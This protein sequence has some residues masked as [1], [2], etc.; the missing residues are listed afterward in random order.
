MDLATIIQQPY[1]SK[2][3]VN[4][5][6]ATDEKNILA[7][8]DQ[9]LSTIILLDYKQILVLSNDQNNLANFKIA[10]LKTNPSVKDFVYEIIYSP[11][12]DKILIICE[13]SIYLTHLPFIEDNFVEKT[14]QIKKVYSHKSLK[15]GK[16]IWLS[17]NRFAFQTSNC[18]KIYEFDNQIQN[19]Q[20]THKYSTQ[21]KLN[22]SYSEEFNGF[23]FIDQDDK[24]ILYRLASFNN[25]HEIFNVV[26][27][28]KS[29]SPN[30][31]QNFKILTLSWFNQ[32]IYSI[33]I[34]NIITH[35][36]LVNDE[37][38]GKSQVESTISGDSENLVIWCFESL[39]LEQDILE[40]YNDNLVPNRYYVK[41][42]KDVYSITLPLNTDNDENDLP[43][44]EVYHIFHDATSTKSK[45]SNI[46]GFTTTSSSIFSI[47]NNKL[48]NL[49]KIGWNK[50]AEIQTDNVT[51]DKTKNIDE[52]NVLTLEIA[53]ML[54]KEVLQ[55][56]IIRSKEDRP[57]AIEMAKTLKNA[58]SIINCEYIEKH[59]NVKTVLNNKKSALIKKIDLL[60]KT[61]SQ[62]QSVNQT[63]KSTNQ[64]LINKLAT[65]LENQEI[66]EKKL[67]KVRKFNTSGE[68]LSKQEQEWMQ[69]AKV[70]EENLTNYKQNIYELK[71]EL[72]NE[73][74]NSSSSAAFGIK[75]RSTFDS[76][77]QYHDIESNLVK[78]TN[79]LENLV[80][81]LKN[82]SIK[83]G[84]F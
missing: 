66:L 45:H 9:N 49:P 44:A 34:G 4:I 75:P 2:L 22:F 17:S 79:D 43:K 10:S 25:T 50:I 80:D 78:N 13:N 63:C 65:F 27:P 18:L 29:N 74:N 55:P 54:K 61:I 56:I 72:N 21:I 39:S 82:L 64:S 83:A 53:E 14:I 24:F 77:L 70:I 6:S 76:T 71:E 37:D 58:I 42:S 31:K 1:K 52:S 81:N 69:Q 38:D 26:P 84:C 40:S 68:Q 15:I 19:I 16:T 23:I 33:S 67:Q 12:G 51:S 3:P 20:L 62:I 28:L 59:N 48:Y 11:N 36:I 8:W 30:L 35:C 41:T 7:T 73:A 60:T 57:S 5:I 47:S 32:A 46:I